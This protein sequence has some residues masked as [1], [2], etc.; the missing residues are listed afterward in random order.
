M[1]ILHWFESI[2]IPV[3]NEFMLLITRFGEETIFLVAA[4]PILPPIKRLLARVP[5]AAELAG[6]IAAVLTG[7][8]SL[9][10]LVQQ[11]YNPFIYFRF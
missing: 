1:E 4:M 7:F 10:L 9:L 8:A 3:L 2:R 5:R 11:S 6:T